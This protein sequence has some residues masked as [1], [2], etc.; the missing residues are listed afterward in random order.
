V[1]ELL[2]HATAAKAKSRAANSPATLLSFMVL[3]LLGLTRLSPAHAGVWTR[4]QSDGG[5]RVG[6]EPIQRT[7]PVWCHPLP[8]G[9]TLTAGAPC[10]IIPTRV[11]NARR[12]ERPGRV[13]TAAR[14]VALGH[15]VRRARGPSI[16]AQGDETS[17]WTCSVVVRQHVA[18]HRAADV[19]GDRHI[20]NDRTPY[21]RC[22]R[23]RAPRG[24]GRDACPPPRC[25][26]D[27][28]ATHRSPA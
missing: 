28:P 18:R 23:A 10:S 24:H 19:T 11:P 13:Q 15:P 8:V 2:L 16:A 22:A 14:V 5:S 25:R 12:R 21:P 20:S 3:I 27:R 1:A 26:P 7:D 4:G 9:G 17:R 6:R